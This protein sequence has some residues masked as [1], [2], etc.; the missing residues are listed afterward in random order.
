MTDHRAT[1][2]ARKKDTQRE[3]EEKDG[4]DPVPC[5]LCL[6]FSVRYVCCSLCNVWCSLSIM[7]GVLCAF[8]LLL[9][10]M[11]GVPCPL[12]LE[13]S[14]HYACCKL[15]CLDKVLHLVFSV[16]YVWRSL[17]SIFVANCCIWCSLC[18]VFV[19][20][21]Y[22]WCSLCIMFVESC[23]VWCSLSVISVGFCFCFVVVCLIVVPYV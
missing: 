1:I 8:C 2:T 9:S 14:V 12:C 21:G 4:T 17:Y 7:S 23:Y 10:L 20:N 18:I 16:H 22:V 6:A 13:F 11:S 3:E 19:A 15:L 5:P